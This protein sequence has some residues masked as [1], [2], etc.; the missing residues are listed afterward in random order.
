MKIKAIVELDVNIEEFVKVEGLNEN[1]TQTDIERTVENYIDEI[2][3]RT[4]YT[5]MDKEEYK[6]IRC[7]TKYLK[8]W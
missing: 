7:V 5:V 2:N 4:F 1:S 8:K 6:L 3:K